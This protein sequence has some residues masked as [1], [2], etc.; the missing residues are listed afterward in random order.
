MKLHRFLSMYFIF[1]INSNI[2]IDEAAYSAKQC[3]KKWQNLQMVAKQ[4]YRDFKR[5]RSGTGKLTQKNLYT[6]KYN[7]KMHFT[8]RRP[9][10][11]LSEHDKIIVFDILGEENP[12]LVE[13]EGGLDR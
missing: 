1:S 8:G 11:E 9:S 2:S 5:Y 13:V 4:S 6:S 3:S 12:T 10:R 7:T